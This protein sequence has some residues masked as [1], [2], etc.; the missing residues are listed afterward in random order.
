MAQRFRAKVLHKGQVLK[1]F[2]HD[3]MH[4]Y[5]ICSGSIGVFEKR[6]PPQTEDDEDEENKEEKQRNSELNPIKLLQQR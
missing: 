4:I 1:E 6:Q 5:F 3:C 2:G